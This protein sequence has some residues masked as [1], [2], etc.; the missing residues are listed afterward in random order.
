[1]TVHSILLRGGV[2]VTE[3]QF[4]GARSA[5]LARFGTHIDVAGR[6]G[7]DRARHAH[8]KWRQDSL[9]EQF[10]R[11]PG[12]RARFD[13]V[14]GDGL[15]LPRELEHIHQRVLEEKHP[16]P[17]ALSLFPVDST[18]QPGAS[19]HTIRRVGEN[20]EAVVHGAGQETSTV[21]ITRDEETFPIL[22]IVCGFEVSIFDQQSAQFAGI[23]VMQR[24]GSAA[25]RAIDR[26]INRIAWFGHAA[27]N[28]RGITDY[29]YLATRV[30]GVAYD[31]T[32]AADDVVDDLHSHANWAEDIS[33]EVFSP[34]KCVT[35][36]RTRNYIM[37]T[38]RSTTTDTTIGKHFLENNEHISAIQSAWELKGI[39]PNG[40][41]GML[42]YRDDPD[43]IMLEAVQPFTMLP[44]Q[45][46]GWNDLV[47]A[48][49]SFGGAIMG[50]VG[51]CILVLVTP[52]TS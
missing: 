22:H 25:K 5:A 52:P 39:G 17:N 2:S 46:S 34:T 43:S 8:W 42:F 23:P 14:G 4:L 12:L 31:G 49:A 41:D 51:N 10:G 30:A 9:A 36:A 37:N 7:I 50:D 38:P 20:G 28:M 27:K 11:D 44:T 1:M 26:K 6:D 3:A 45:R 48:Y 19:H 21:G 16:I 47:L 32:A 35:T 18:V 15:F 33:S 13:A 24:L 29:P 40:E